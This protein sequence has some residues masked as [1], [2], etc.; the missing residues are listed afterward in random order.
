VIPACSPD[1]SSRLKKRWNGTNLRKK[2][3]AVAAM[4]QRL[5]VLR[6]IREL[7]TNQGVAARLSRRHCALA[8][9]CCR[10]TLGTLLAAPARAQSHINAAYPTTTKSLIPRGISR[11]PPH[12]RAAKE[13][14][15]RYGAMHDDAEPACQ[16][17]KTNATKETPEN[18]AR[19]LWRGRP[20]E[21][22]HY[23]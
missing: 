15:P 23:R 13:G 22:R 10:V 20:R 7:I 1:N 14:C 4:T 3:A 19:P 5:T 6:K 21:T 11:D 16:N 12:A 9:T 17:S 2:T 18:E 8:T